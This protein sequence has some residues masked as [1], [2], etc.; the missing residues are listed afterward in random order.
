MPTLALITL[1]SACTAL[2]AP[3]SLEEELLSERPFPHP[4]HVQCLVLNDPD[5]QHVLW[6]AATRRGHA[7]PSGSG[8]H[9]ALY[10][11]ALD[12]AARA[13]RGEPLPDAARLCA[14]QTH[15]G[16]DLS[17][18]Y[19]DPRWRI[20]DALLLGSPYPER[21]LPLSASEDDDRLVRALVVAL[22]ERWEPIRKDSAPSEQPQS[23]LPFADAFAVWQEPEAVLLGRS[24]EAPSAVWAD[25]APDPA[26]DLL[27]L[28][29]PDRQPQHGIGELRDRSS[30]LFAGTVSESGIH[31]MF[32][33]KDID[34]NALEGLS[35]LGEQRF[36]VRERS[37]KVHEVDL[38]SKDDWSSAFRY[39]CEY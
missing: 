24:A 10:D 14:R 33:R 39:G 9:D 15:L 18:T 35:A 6:Q 29:Y 12:M 4:A 25:A 20:L 30:P 5:R 3:P 16:A 34:S 26:G 11:A 7:W 1:W 22:R 13:R 36:R 21:L 17:P 8:A 32:L 31:W 27:L 2:T 37:G 38:N 19:H 23:R 28:H